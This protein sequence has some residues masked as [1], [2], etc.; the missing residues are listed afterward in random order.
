MGKTSWIEDEITNLEKEGLLVNFREVET[1]IGAKIRINGKEVFN[2]S[3]NNYLGLA[4]N[5]RLKKAAKEAIDKFGVGP[6][7]VRTIAGTMSIHNELEKKLAEFK[8]AEDVIIFQTGFL[9]NLATVPAVVG[10]NDVIF[11][12]EL[13][14]A[15][16]IDACRLSKAKVVR[17]PHL[18]YKEL[19]TL[20]KDEKERHKKL[21]ITDG[22]F[23]MDGDVAPLPQLS[24][25]AEKYDAL[26]MVDDAHGEGVLGEGG[27]GIVDH[28]K[29]HGKVDLEVGT[30]S[31][32]FGVIGGTVAGKKEIIT[33]LRQRARPFLFSSA[34]TP[35]DTAACR[36]AVNILEESDDLVNK[37]WK[38]TKYFKN[39][40]S[41]TGFDIGKSETPIIPIMV[42][43]AKLAKEFSK[44]L[45]DKGVFGVA[46]TYPTVAM[47]KARIRLIIS[48][49]HTKPD[50]DAA[51]SILQHTGKEFKLI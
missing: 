50:L 28:F 21:I 30:M 38:N 19:E 44:A 39:L 48:A 24:E 14:H 26:L 40:L 51:Y 45:F 23:S 9:A 27:R 47:G 33:W 12:D 16:I 15:S 18:N 46:I 2:F 20:I 3:S 22:V 35:A 36:E 25:I 43:D 5:E 11:S 7:A 10:E 42:G 4:N 17:Y 29:L 41:K 49:A 37:L 32:A 34:M 6:A 31:K 8:K 1:P 13:N